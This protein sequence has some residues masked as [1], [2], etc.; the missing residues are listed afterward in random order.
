MVD[1]VTVRIVTTRVGVRDENVK[2]QL[3]MYVHSLISQC[4]GHVE[5][6]ILLTPASVYFWQLGFNGWFFPGPIN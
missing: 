3:C 6:G 5:H 4:V 2:Q 1:F